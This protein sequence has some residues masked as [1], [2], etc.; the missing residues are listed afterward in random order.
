ME[1]SGQLCC[2]PTL[3]LAK[4]LGTDWVEGLLDCTAILDVM[5]KRKLQTHLPEYESQAFR[6]GS[7]HSTGQLVETEEF[8]LNIMT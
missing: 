4:I 3:L 8:L 5:M 6:Q 2:Q 1:L 7:A